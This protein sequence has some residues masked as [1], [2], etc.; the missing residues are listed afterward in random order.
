MPKKKIIFETKLS[1]G[2]VVM[3]TAAI[4]DF[5][6]VYS[7]KYDVGV[8]TFFPDLFLNNPYVNQFEFQKVSEGKFENSSKFEDENGDPIESLYVHYPIINDCNEQPYH[9]LHGYRKFLQAHYGPIPQGPYRGDIHLSEEEKSGTEILDR[10]G[11]KGPFWIV[12]AGGKRDFTTKWWDPNRYREVVR[13]FRGKIQFVQIGSKKDFHQP[14]PEAI[15]L[16]GKTSVRDLVNLTYHCNGIVCPIT[17]I[18]HLAAAVPLRKDF[19]LSSR[20]CVVVA[21]SR[22]PAHWTQYPGHQHL[23]R[24]GMLPCSPLGGGCWKGR[25][26]VIDD[27]S[28]SNDEKALCSLPVQVNPTL[29]IPKCMDMI[30]ASDVIRSIELYR[31]LEP[32]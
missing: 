27:D 30:K 25:C 17:L 23:H 31:E 10:F 8:S 6:S 3:L 22:E 11:I 29:R 26:Q 1:P 24:N 12:C 20:P 2:D 13:Y 4:R 21:G 7:Y 28:P 14:I 19:P 15:N 32:I 18:M 9:F 5:Y 16:V